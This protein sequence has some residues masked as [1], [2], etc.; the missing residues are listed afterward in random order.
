M[1]ERHEKTPVRHPVS[2]AIA[3]I[4][5]TP[6]E[7]PRL[8]PGRAM[9]G[10]IVGPRPAP[11]ANM[12]GARMKTARARVPAG[13][14]KSAV[15]HGPPRCAGHAATAT[16]VALLH[17]HRQVDIGR[18]EIG[19]MK[20]TR[21]ASED[22]ALRPPTGVHRHTD[23]PTTIGIT[24]CTTT[25]HHRPTPRLAEPMETDMEGVG[26]GPTETTRIEI[27]D[28]RLPGT[29]IVARRRVTIT[30]GGTT[31][32]IEVATLRLRT[33]GIP[34]H[35]I[36]GRRATEK[37]IAGHRADGSDDRLHRPHVGT[38]GAQMIAMAR[39]LRAASATTT[40]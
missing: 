18:I 6:I 1:I 34:D 15:V 29:S 13:R 20:T 32:Q 33:V 7:I 8:Q 14:R 2:V 17:L 9:S 25:D 16:T 10:P 24:R 30:V 3:T 35:R 11:M 23:M 26:M 31:V 39:R 27:V 40:R 37:K 21:I 28:P 5:G 19:E 22:I 38:T 4:D 36:A 12:I